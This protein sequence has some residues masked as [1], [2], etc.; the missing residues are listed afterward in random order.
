MNERFL[1]LTR[2]GKTYATPY[3]PSVIVKDFDVHVR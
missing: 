1:E 2:L 3:G